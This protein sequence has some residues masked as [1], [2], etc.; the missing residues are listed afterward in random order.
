MDVTILGKPEGAQQEGTEIAQWVKAFAAKT[1]P[2][3]NSHNPQGRRGH[4]VP[5]SCSLTSTSKLWHT[6]L[7]NS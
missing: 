3:F 5:V 6:L 4:S 7:N 1:E 2:E